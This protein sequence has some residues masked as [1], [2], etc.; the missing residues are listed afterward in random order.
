MVQFIIDFLL[1][2]LDSSSD[3]D[4]IPDNGTWF[5]LI[6]NG[7]TSINYGT[8]GLQK[9]DKVVELAKKHGIYLLL[10]LTNNWN[11]MLDIDDS[12]PTIASFP[13]N[14]LCNS[15]GKF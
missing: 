6:A 15:Y 2:W 4:I 1:R 9:L 11:P 12:E 8:H 5:Q 14:T 10:S 3:V 13:R 7:T